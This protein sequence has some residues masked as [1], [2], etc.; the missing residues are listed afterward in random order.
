MTATKDFQASGE[1]SMDLQR[2]H[3]KLLN[4]NFFLYSVF[5][6]RFC[7][8]VRFSNPDPDPPTLFNPGQS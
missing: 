8:P 2:K 4:M 1:D 5:A 6:E 3:L 7:L